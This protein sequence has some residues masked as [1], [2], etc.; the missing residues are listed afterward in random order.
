MLVGLGHSLDVSSRQGRHV[1]TMP[2][3]TRASVYCIIRMYKLKV[4]QEDIDYD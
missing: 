2:Q 3:K 1:D 4:K